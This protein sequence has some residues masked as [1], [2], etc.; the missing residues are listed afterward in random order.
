MKRGEVYYKFIFP[1][2][3]SL[4]GS[5]G[6]SFP[7][8]DGSSS[9]SF[10]TWD[11]DDQKGEVRALCR[12][13]PER[14][15]TYDQLTATNPNPM[16]ANGTNG[17]SVD[18]K[19]AIKNYIDYWLSL[20]KYFN[21]R[22]YWDHDP[23]QAG[24]ISLM[25]SHSPEVGLT[26]TEWTKFDGG[27]GKTIYCSL[28]VSS[29]D[30]FYSF[31]L[32]DEIITK[33][34]L[35][36]KVVRPA[37]YKGAGGNKTPLLRFHSNWCFNYTE[38]ADIFNIINVQT[39]Q[40]KRVF[41]QFYFKDGFQYGPQNKDNTFYY[42]NFTN[43]STGVTYS[44][45]DSNLHCK[46]ILG[47]YTDELGTKYTGSYK[48]FPL[49][50]YVD[51]YYINDDIPANRVTRHTYSSQV[52]NSIAWKG[53]E[54]ASNYN[55][56]LKRDFIALEVTR[57]ILY[58][59]NGDQLMYNNVVRD[60]HPIS[61]IPRIIGNATGKDTVLSYEPPAEYINEGYD[62]CY[63]NY[64]TTD[65]LSV[66]AIGTPPL[67][68][69][70]NI[71]RYAL[72][73]RPP[74]TDCETVLV[75][76]VAN[77]DPDTI[78]DSDPDKVK[79]LHDLDWQQYAIPMSIR[80]VYKNVSSSIT[81]SKIHCNKRF[82]IAYPYYQSKEGVIYGSKL[83]GSNT[84]CNHYQFHFHFNEAYD[85]NRLDRESL[86]MK[87]LV[88]Y[89]HDYII[90]FHRTASVFTD[91]NNFFN[92]QKYLFTKFKQQYNAE[93]SALYIRKKYLTDWDPST[94]TRAEAPLSNR[95]TVCQAYYLHVPKR[96]YSIDVSNTDYLRNSDGTSTFIPTAATDPSDNNKLYFRRENF[97]KWDFVGAN[98]WGPVR[99]RNGDGTYKEKCAVYDSWFIA[100]FDASKSIVQQITGSITIDNAETLYNYLTEKIPP[101]YIDQE[102]YPDTYN[103]HDDWNDLYISSFGISPY[104]IVEDECYKFFPSKNDDSGHIYPLGLLNNHLQINGITYGT[105]YSKVIVGFKQMYDYQYTDA[106]HFKYEYDTSTGTYVYRP[107]R[108]IYNVHN[109]SYPVDYIDAPVCTAYVM[110]YSQS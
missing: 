60:I 24:G 100:L 12:I 46:D 51:H 22:N 74:F 39:N 49:D 40:E 68:I 54:H 83:S 28:M 87:D 9:N 90:A 70:Y 14:V 31:C 29:G 3:D 11:G 5:D 98:G 41:A 44:P 107:V 52:A 76:W 17:W 38:R 75:M 47:K 105:N 65:I 21:L 15:I 69:P 97:E 102:G 58:Y 20:P 61:D 66:R 26:S 13:C 8:M 84:N 53:V 42:F 57:R 6:D 25:V 101:R 34:G 45:T 35:E 86:F 95:D 62:Y 85:K 4:S 23:P 33:S 18:K 106:Y 96:L 92:I 99:D 72:N 1:N 108:V 27:N 67:Q 80:C 32:P 91:G 77:G 59:Y 88:D 36:D 89:S 82:L 64:S 10:P 50:E 37:Q 110:N 94:D 79:K 2:Y 109:N 81:E 78:S 104:N 71:L 48:N 30:F 103:A 93:C 43:D 55:E 7:T 63:N 73:D 16:Y 56:D 19:T